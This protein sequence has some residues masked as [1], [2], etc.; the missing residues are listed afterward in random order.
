MAFNMNYIEHAELNVFP[1]LD[2][3]VAESFSVFVF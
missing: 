2:A 1:A 3:A